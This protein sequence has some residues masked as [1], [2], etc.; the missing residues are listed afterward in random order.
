MPDFD[1]ESLA[2]QILTAATLHLALLRLIDKGLHDI[3]LPPVT[4][5]QIETMWSAD[6]MNGHRQVGLV[7]QAR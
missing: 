7:P 1:E 5:M 3:A 2:K 6:V 4:R